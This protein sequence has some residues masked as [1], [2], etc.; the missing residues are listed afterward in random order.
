[1][2]KE[3]A[4]RIASLYERRPLQSYAR[5]KVRMDPL[6]EMVV[7]ILAEWNR[8]VV[9]VG[10]GVGILAFCLREHGHTGPIVGFDFDARKIAEARK[11]A[12]R[13]R[14]LDFVTADAKS[15]LPEGHDVVLLDLLHYLEPQDQLVVLANAARAAR[16]GGLVIIRQGIADGSWR[17]RASLIMDAFGRM[18]RW[19]KAG[20]LHFPSRATLLA[21]FDGFDAEIR[22]LWGRTPFNNYLFVF[23]ANPAQAADVSS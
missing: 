22:P 14:S 4:E 7:D 10:C 16:S 6:Y 21:A 18:I 12:R 17:H 15:P 3:V 20:R 9:D 19:M 2:T 1:M 11:A 23:R 13:Y 8:P 5:W